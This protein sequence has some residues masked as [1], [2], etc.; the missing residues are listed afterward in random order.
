M[1][2]VLYASFKIKVWEDKEYKLEKQRTM[3]LLLEDIKL[4]SHVSRRETA[5]P[6]QKADLDFSHKVSSFIERRQNSALINPAQKY[7][8]EDLKEDSSTNFEEDR[9]F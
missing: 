4:T 9:R 1:E 3:A 5:L 8:V 2:K 6:S 7:R